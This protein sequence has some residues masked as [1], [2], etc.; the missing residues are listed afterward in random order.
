MSTITNSAPFPQKNL[1]T[2]LSWRENHPQLRE[3]S[4]LRLVAGL[5]DGCPAWLIDRYG[6][7]V[8]ATHY[9]STPKPEVMFE[10]L[11]KL[12]PGEHLLFKFRDTDG[13]FDS[14]G[15]I[16]PWN[17][18]SLGLKWE[19]RPDIRHD[20]GL[21]LDT[22]ASRT[23]VNSVAKNKKIL[24]LFSYTCGFGLV[25]AQGGAHQVTNIDASKDYLDWGRLN[26]D[27]NG[28]D[29]RNFEDTVQ[30]YMARHLRR[31]ESSKDQAYDLIVADPPAFLVGRGDDRLGRKL[32]PKLLSQ[33][34]MTQAPLLLLIN[35]DRSFLKKRS[36]LAFVAEH[37]PAYQLEVLPHSP[38][39]LGQDPKGM[40]P[41]YT[42]PDV[43]IARRPLP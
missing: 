25:A 20:F 42:V 18:N 27:L 35:N 43:L 40:D 22:H 1:V 7:G 17:C 14:L 37:L 4:T 5:S 36:W 26:A 16:E 21:F 30:K 19:V 39:C 34:K 24:N 11:Q 13:R 2:S 29:F 32:W 10:N 8:T 6:P 33:L 12:L 28:L 3:R 41:H 31:L 15:T 9:G 38:D 23:W